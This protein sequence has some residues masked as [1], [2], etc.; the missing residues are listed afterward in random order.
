MRSKRGWVGTALVLEEY[1]DALMARDSHRARTVVVR[2]LDAGVDPRRLALDVL[3]PALHEF[4]QRWEHGDISVAQEH[5]ATG[6]TEGVLAL[7]AQRMRRPPAGG[8]L[9]IVACP[10]GERHGLAARMI[11][12][13]LEAE[14][15]EVLVVGPDV[16]VRDLYELVADEQPDLVCLS[17]T[18][19]DATEPAIELAGMLGTVEPPPFIVL[20][21]QAWNGGTAVAREMGADLVTADLQ[22]LLSVIRERLPPLPEDE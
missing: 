6:V 17:A 1:M 20:G 16:P 19:P 12:D 14:A 15:W 18:M 3:A 21:G 11:G 2:A 22:E 9:A 8:R 7:V 4:G 5:Y 10:P 13:F